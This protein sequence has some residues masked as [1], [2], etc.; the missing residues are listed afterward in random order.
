VRQRRPPD[1]A[2]FEEDGHIMASSDE[3]AERALMLRIYRTWG[4]EI[5]EA[6]S[7]S[8]VLPSFLAALT[9]NESGGNAA[10]QVF[11]PGIYK[12]LQA[13]VS[14]EEPAFG[15]L[16]AEDL[17]S[18]SLS[19]FEPRIEE[20][21]LRMIQSTA[22]QPDVSEAAREK[23]L[24]EMATSWGLTQIMGYHVIRW[25]RNIQDLLDPATHFQFAIDL[26]EELGR[27]FQLNLSRDFESLFR[28]WN[29]GHPSG[30]TFDPDYAFRGIQR[31]R[32]YGAIAESSG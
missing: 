3:K 28:S 15:S 27:R 8:P 9:A 13:V 6:T 22:L 4:R 29:T 11:E 31:M 26:L 16:V 1:E 10:A 24:R 20:S 19:E 2:N 21:A 12:R 25:K 7:N 30:K 17:L 18:Q 23:A 5:S 32:I 14:G